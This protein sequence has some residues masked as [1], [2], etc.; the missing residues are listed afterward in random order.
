MHG[1]TTK[2]DADQRIVQ[3]AHLRASHGQGSHRS[4]I[5][6]AGRSHSPDKDANQNRLASLYQPYF[7]QN[8]ELQIALARAILS[9]QEQLATSAVAGKLTTAEIKDYR[10]FVGIDFR[11]SVFYGLV[12]ERGE[13]KVTPQDALLPGQSLDELKL[14]RTLAQR[15]MVQSPLDVVSRYLLLQTSFVEPERP[16]TS[17]IWV[18]QC[19]R[20]WP[21]SP[22]VLIPVARLAAVSP[23]DDVSLQVVQQALRQ[24]PSAFDQLWPFIEQLPNIENQD[25]AVPDDPRVLILAIESKLPSV[26]PRNILLSGCERFLI[27]ALLSYRKSVVPHPRPTGVFQRRFFCSDRGVVTRRFA[28]AQSSGHAIFVLRGAAKDGRFRRSVGTSP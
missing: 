19:Q 20:L 7:D 2:F 25:Q 22:S 3:A 21:N 11:R 15:A 13:D 12:R 10:Q 4:R 16:E 14:A 27:V 6:R 8:P 24:Q 18:E 26:K 23:A 5:A 9:R 28:G 1:P 17:R